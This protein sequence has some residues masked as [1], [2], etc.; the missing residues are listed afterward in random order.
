MFRDI[1]GLAL[2]ILAQRMAAENHD[3]RNSRRLATHYREHEEAV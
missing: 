3:V 1:F 2:A